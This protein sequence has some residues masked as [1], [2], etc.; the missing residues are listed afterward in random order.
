MVPPRRA[1]TYNSRGI[2][3]ESVLSHRQ[4]CKLE[5]EHETAVDQ[6]RLQDGKRLCERSGGARVQFE[7]TAPS[8]TLANNV[9]NDH[10]II[11]HVDLCAKQ[12]REDQSATQPCD[13][14]LSAN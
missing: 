7:V 14:T 11:A 4:V 2:Y 8:I 6:I 5:V 13:A 12:C 10:E 1:C 9:K 3:L